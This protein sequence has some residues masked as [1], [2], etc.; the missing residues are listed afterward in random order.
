MQ[1]GDINPSESNWGEGKRAERAGGAPEAA[2]DGRGAA[3]MTI[4]TRPDEVSTRRMKRSGGPT[5]GQFVIRRSTTWWIK[6]AKVA[7]G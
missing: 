1:H 4:A 7:R 5:V 3:S 6:L 2:A